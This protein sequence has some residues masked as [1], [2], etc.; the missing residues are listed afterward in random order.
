ML[1]EG[2]YSVLQRDHSLR[3]NHHLLAI[4]IIDKPSFLY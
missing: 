3:Y 2:T 4:I 1:G